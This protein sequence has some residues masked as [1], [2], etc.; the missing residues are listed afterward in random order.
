MR[1]NR[2][3]CVL[4]FVFIV[5]GALNRA[6]F[7]YYKNRD[8][9]IAKMSNQMYA[10]LGFFAILTWAIYIIWNRRPIKAM[11]QYIAILCCVIAAVAFYGMGFAVDLGYVSLETAHSSKFSFFV[12]FFCIVGIASWFVDKYINRPARK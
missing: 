3:G 7:Y 1:F 10:L 12:I 2:T 8:A 6:I 9:S 4:V 5:L 11:R